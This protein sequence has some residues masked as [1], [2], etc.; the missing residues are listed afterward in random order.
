MPSIKYLFCHSFI[1]LIQLKLTS[2]GSHTLT[3]DQFEGE[4][5]HSINGAINESKT[6]FIEAGLKP[7]LLKN[8]EK[9]NIL[10][11][12]FG[13]GLNA[14]LTLIETLIGKATHI[15]YVGV[16][17]FPVSKEIAAQLNYPGLL[18]FQTK[19]FLELHECEWN[20]EI[21]INV[22]FILHKIQADFKKFALSEKF[23]LVYYDA[24]SPATQPELWEQPMLQKI[25]DLMKPNGVLTTYCAK[26]AFKRTLR[27]IGF[28]IEPLPGPLGKR[29]ITRAIKKVGSEI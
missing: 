28:Q 8:P 10:E 12:G 23:D 6:V 20:K 14:F 22:Y 29:E 2:D 11:I 4:I 7:L 27:T 1:I 16:D 5:Y 21:L 17:A 3:T 15:K 19:N 18:N 26:G 25:Y 9:L 13:S 24:F